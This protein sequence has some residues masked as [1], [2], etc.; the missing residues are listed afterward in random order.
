MGGIHGASVLADLGH[1]SVMRVA[2]AIA[3]CLVALPLLAETPRSRE[4]PIEFMRLHPC[5]GGP[6]AGHT[7][8]ACQGYVRD[9]I[10]PLCKD[11]PDT[12]ENMQW[13]TVAAGHAKD[14]WECK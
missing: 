6:D 2:L 14:K 5:P 13:Q 4:T 9:H 12:V 8:G 3:L 7:R 11:G 1:V 10:I